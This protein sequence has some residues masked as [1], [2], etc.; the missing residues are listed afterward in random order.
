MADRVIEIPEIKLRRMIVGIKGET[1]L[2]TN[3]F[4]ERKRTGYDCRS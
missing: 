3:R 1:P 2:I 4:G